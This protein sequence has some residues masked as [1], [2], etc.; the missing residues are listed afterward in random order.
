MTEYMLLFVGKGAPQE[1]AEDDHQTAAF[2]TS[3]VDWMADLGKHGKLK[4]GGP[5][6][7]EGKEITGAEVAE[8]AL[9]PVDIGAFALIDTESYDE[10][11]GIA[12]TAPH[13][14]LGG[15]TIVRP[16]VGRG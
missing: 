8:L 4:A 16:C 12:K 9:Q 1:V 6:L 7:P 3:W 5:F 15:T 11:V 10:A 14:A 13:M 2:V